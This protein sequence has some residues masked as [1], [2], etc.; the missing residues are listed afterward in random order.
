MRLHQMAFLL[1]SRAFENSHV[2]NEK[3]V[4]V[5]IDIWYLCTSYWPLAIFQQKMHHH[6]E[7]GQLKHS[8]NFIQFCV[9]ANIRFCQK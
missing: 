7:T 3:I 1:L 4:F 8:V 2:F 6:D 9:A 5:D